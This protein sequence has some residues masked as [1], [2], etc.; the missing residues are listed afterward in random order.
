M[1]TEELS[2]YIEIELQ[3]LKYYSLSQSRESLTESSDIYRDLKEMPYSKK[4]MSLDKRCCPC[5]LTSDQII[6]KNTNISDISIS[7]TYSRGDNVFSPLEVF[8]KIYPERKMEIINRL[9][10]D[11]NGCE[12]YNIV[13]FFNKK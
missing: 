11:Y 10:N 12:K 2:K 6:D 7:K 5:V 13:R 1:T 4:R 8:F 3:W 9:K